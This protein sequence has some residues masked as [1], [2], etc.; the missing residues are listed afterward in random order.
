[1]ASLTRTPVTVCLGVFLT[2]TLLV[3][4]ALAATIGKSPS[5]Q[6]E[7]PCGPALPHVCGHHGKRVVCAQWGSVVKSGRTYRCC[8]Q[9]KCPA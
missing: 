7:L 9:W 6:A 5:P 8:V 2:L 1:M 4:G 3:S